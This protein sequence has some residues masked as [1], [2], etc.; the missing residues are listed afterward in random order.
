M[1]HINPEIKKLL[2][3]SAH[4]IEAIAK[5]KTAP[6]RTGQLI[7]DINVDR[8]NINRM[9]AAVGNTTHA[10]YAEPVHEGTGIYGKS[11]KPITPKH[12][13]GLRTPYGVFKSVLGQKANPYLENAAKEYLNSGALDAAIKS[14]GGKISQ[15][16]AAEFRKLFEKFK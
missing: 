11:K 10:P 1:D 3:R 7:D 4:Q 6:R 15:S 12:K 9:E 5:K 2:L 14:F 13:K 8:S 16:L